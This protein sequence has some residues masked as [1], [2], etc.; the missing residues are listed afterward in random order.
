MFEKIL[1]ELLF[2]DK[3]TDQAKKRCLEVI[4]NHFNNASWLDTVFKHQDNPEGLT[5][6]NYMFKQFMEAYYHN[7]Q[8]RSS[9]V[10]RLAPLFCKLA[11]ESNFQNNNPD[12]AKLQRLSNILFYIYNIGSSG[13]LD[14]SKINLDTTYEQLDNEFGSVIDDLNK[15]EN[16]RIANTEYNKNN[17]YDIIGPVD[18]ETAHKY[19]NHS[20]STS[21]L[22]Y[23][24]S[25]NTWAY[26]TNNDC[27][28]AY[29]LLK[30][31]WENISEQHDDKSNN[32]YDTYGLSMIFV[33]I[34]GQGGLSYCNT[35]WNHNANYELPHSC[36]HAM[37]KE[38]IS[39]LIGERFDEV[40]KPSSIWQDA[41]NKAMQKLYNGLPLKDIFDENI[42]YENDDFTLIKLK[43]KWNFI[44]SN[45]EII[46]DLWFDEIG[47]FRGD[48]AKVKLNDKGDNFI[49]RN[50]ELISN[51]QWF[52][53]SDILM[54]NV[55]IVEVGPKC[56]FI[57][58]NGDN[59]NNNLWFDRIDYLNDSIKV[60]LNGK[61]N[62][63]FYNGKLIGNNWFEQLYG[64]NNKFFKVYI[65]G[66][67][68]LLNKNGDLIN[69]QCYDKIGQFNDGF[70]IVLIDDKSNF[71]DENGRLLSDQW[72]DDVLEFNEGFS[73]VN[74]GEK[75][76]FINTNGEL[77][78]KQWFNNAFDFYNGLAKI[79]SDKGVNF[80]NTN[81]DIISDIWFDASGDLTYRFILVGIY[82]NGWK[83]NYIDSNGEL[84]SKNQWFSDARNFK[85]VRPRQ[86]Y[87]SVKVDNNPM[88]IDRKG[89]LF[90][91]LPNLNES[92]VSRI[93][94]ESIKKY[95]L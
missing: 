32:A 38:M 41:L 49:K 78:S 46:S 12:S 75:W 93:L 39:E 24:Q 42:K 59:I 4:R 79:E 23:T 90:N 92:L 62:I 36:D 28:N 64:F 57:N 88:W 29:I 94:K 34:D 18:Y 53:W 56:A 48:F 55:A 47:R 63:A 31:G 51:N 7:P 81:G 71:I 2:E 25:R 74:L 73:L 3:R 60:E 52:D 15:Q 58:S 16:D 33:F 68:N 27:N 1:K 61:Y 40:F 44:N 84:L 87:A 82:D 77:I 8:M 21:K 89:N 22:C 76:N 95:I 37:S 65:N 69:N 20:C 91:E 5:Y 10:M 70:A 45:R 85:M 6:I 19:G 26:Y 80:I 30:K 86:V 54:D 17:D 35:R 83:W 13:K 67:F 66:G 9:A 11:F 14:I 50:G 43:N 72:F